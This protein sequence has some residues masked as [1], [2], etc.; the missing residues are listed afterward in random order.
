MD[1]LEGY[2]IGLGMIIFIGPV[3]FLL[4]SSTLKG[5]YIAGLMVAIGIVI[6]DLICVILCMYGL[7]PLLTHPDSHFWLAITGSILLV[8][9]GVKYI[10]TKHTHQEENMILYSHHQFSFFVKGFLI[11]FVNP[12][13][14]MVWMGVIKYTEQRVGGNSILFLSGTLLGIFSTDLLKVVLAKRIKQF[15]NPSTL[16]WIYRVFGVIMIAFGI[17]MFFYFY[18]K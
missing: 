3:F 6:S 7:A 14:V 4:I 12:F 9:I 13:V 10:L 17:R 16:Q 1:L 2:L 8:G 11:N 18:F 15:I 5:G